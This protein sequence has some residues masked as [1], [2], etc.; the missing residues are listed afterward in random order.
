MKMAFVVFILYL[1]A[2]ASLGDHLLPSLVIGGF[3]AYGALMTVASLQR[4]KQVELLNSWPKTPAFIVE[5]DT[6][7][8]INY[9]SKNGTRGTT[10][11]LKWRP[12]LKYRYDVHGVSYESYNVYSNTIGDHTLNKK[13]AQ[14]FKQA[15]K[16]NSSTMIHYNSEDP[17]ESFVLHPNNKNGLLFGFIMASMCGYLVINGGIT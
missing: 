2:M 1:I 4:D 15:Y 17:S 13:Q 11:S 8:D 6:P 9:G 14:K 12:H 10:G 3:G 5:S 16:P 7:R